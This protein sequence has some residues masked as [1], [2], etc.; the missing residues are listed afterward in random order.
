MTKPLPTTFMFGPIVRRTIE[1]EAILYDKSC[2]ETNCKGSLIGRWDW[3]KRK[4]S[5]FRC[6]AI[7]CKNGNI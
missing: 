5:T 7:K 3:S 2:P 6:S 1:D 4:Y